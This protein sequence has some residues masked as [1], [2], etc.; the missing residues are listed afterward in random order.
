MPI[1]QIYEDVSA[2]LSSWA[3]HFGEMLPGGAFNVHAQ[4]AT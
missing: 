1:D 3:D 2:K 4:E